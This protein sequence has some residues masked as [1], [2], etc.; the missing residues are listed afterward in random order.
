RLTGRRIASLVPHNVL[1]L[2]SVIRRLIDEARAAGWDPG[3]PILPPF[4]SPLAGPFLDAPDRRKRPRPE[5]HDDEEYLAAIRAAPDDDAPRLVYAD[6]LLERGDARGE[7]I[8]LS[9]LAKTREPTKE[10]RLRLAELVGEHEVA[11]LGPLSYVTRAR[12]WRRGFLHDA[13]LTRRER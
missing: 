6:V 3:Q 4:H 2:P 5:E 13:E 12:R 7:M 1:V 8:I 9:C 11:W 10:E